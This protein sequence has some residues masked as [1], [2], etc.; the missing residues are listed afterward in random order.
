MLAE[1]DWDVLKTIRLWAKASH[2]AIHDKI[3][4]RL[5]VDPIDRFSL[6]FKLDTSLSDKDKFPL[7]LSDLIIMGRNPK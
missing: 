4:S 1:N 6:Q 3:A 5:K 2:E 7:K